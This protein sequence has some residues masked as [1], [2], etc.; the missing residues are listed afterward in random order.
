MPSNS[1]PSQATSEQYLQMLVMLEV[2]HTYPLVNY[3]SKFPRPAR[4]G[5][6]NRFIISDDL[7]HLIMKE[8]TVSLEE[9]NS[10]QLHN[11]TIMHI[12]AT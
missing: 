1:V 9:Y 2:I 10:V 7:I 6:K 8:R 4:T 5:G 3:S 11:V 12:V